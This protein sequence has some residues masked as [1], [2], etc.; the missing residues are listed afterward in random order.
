MLTMPHV[1]RVGITEVGR[2][3]ADL[4]VLVVEDEFMVS[5]LIEDLLRGWGVSKITTASSVHGALTALKSKLPDVAL[6]DVMLGDHASFPTAE[7]LKSK[8]VPFLFVTALTDSG[9]IPE[10]RDHPRI[11]KPF[12]DTELKAALQRVLSAQS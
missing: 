6:L 2:S 3:F 9:M 12:A 10:W 1:R 5:M 11:E 7:I 4:H 8:N